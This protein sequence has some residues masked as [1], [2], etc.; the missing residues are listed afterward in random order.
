MIAEHKK[1]KCARY[2]TT[3]KCKQI[4]CIFLFNLMFLIS[5]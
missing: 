4:A 5:N 2:Q 1:Y 3:R